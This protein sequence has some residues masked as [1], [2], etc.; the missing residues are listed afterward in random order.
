VNTATKWILGSVI[1]GGV[2]A[3]L[4]VP[5]GP[6]DR[7]NRWTGSARSDSVY[8]VWNAERT[9]LNVIRR[10]VQRGEAREAARAVGD[11]RDDVPVFRFD[12]ALGAGATAM[13]QQRVADEL[14]GAGSDPIRYPITIIARLDTSLAGG[15]YTQAIVLPE[16]AGEPCTVVFSLPA[17]QRNKFQA[18]AAHRVLG[19]CAFYAAFGAPGA[20][21]TRWLLETRGASARYLKPPSAFAG[22]TSRMRLGVT[23]IGW[24]NLSESLLR[25]RMAIAEGCDRFI[26]PDTYSPGFYEQVEA[27]AIDRT[28]LRTAFPGVDVLNS[29]TWSP[30]GPRLRAGALAAL[31]AELGSER[32]GALWRDERGLQ[33]AYAASA[34]RP[35]SSWVARYVESRT[36]EYV[37]GPGI[38]A[39]QVALALVIALAAFGLGVTRSPRQMT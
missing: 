4:L 28:P 12:P 33:D 27:V 9:R 31:A 5:K 37:A 18:S 21:T 24:D 17:A 22:D 29:T 2:A 8:Q 20:A 14:R 6:D 34:G 3:S 1:V 13:M 32:F 15:I 10:V 26:G 19:T 23:Y 30:D 7:W 35:L 25:C 16:R 11:T 38:P 36:S 39:L